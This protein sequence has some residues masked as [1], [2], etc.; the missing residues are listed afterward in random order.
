MSAA[1]APSGTP[2]AYQPTRISTHAIEHAL[3]QLLAPGRSFAFAYQQGGHEFYQLSVP[4]TEDATEAGGTW[5][6]DFSTSQWHERM[7]LDATTAKSRTAPPRHRRLWRKWWW[8]TGGWAPL[9]VRA[10]LLHR[11]RGPH[12]PHAP[13]AHI[14]QEEKRIR[15]NSFELQAETGRRG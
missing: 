7:Y 2:R 15:F 9:H 5:V 1:A 11:R 6:Y 10:R 8:A 14:S 4:G 3:S 13:D 12:P